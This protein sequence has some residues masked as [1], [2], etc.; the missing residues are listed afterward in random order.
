MNGEY[1]ELNKYLNLINDEK[2][3]KLIPQNIRAGITI[4]GVSGTYTGEATTTD[5]TESTSDTTTEE[6]T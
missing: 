6:T 5:T 1:S 4:L 2:N 3:T